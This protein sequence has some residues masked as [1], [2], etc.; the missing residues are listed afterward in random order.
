MKT[1]L[2]VHGVIAAASLF[3]FVLGS[4]VAQ[5]APQGLSERIE[6]RAVNLEVVVTDRDGQRVVGLES[7][8]FTHSRL[9]P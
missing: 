5:D 7:D 1:H 9:R 6:V 8:A 3:L 2:S 4:S